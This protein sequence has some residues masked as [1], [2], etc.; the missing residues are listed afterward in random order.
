VTAR[1]RLARRVFAV[2]LPLALVLAMYA[3]EW[4]R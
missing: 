3:V 2:C 4:M 1:L